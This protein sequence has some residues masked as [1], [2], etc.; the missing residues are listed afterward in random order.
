MSLPLP[1]E[2]L[3][4]SADLKAHV[5]QGGH[6]GAE[7]I[8]YTDEADTFVRK[9]AQ[10]STGSARLLKQAVKQRLFAAQG[11]GFPRVRDMGVDTTRRAWF[12]MDYV[13][14]RTLGDLVRTQAP[15]D[16]QRIIAAIA[17]LLTLFRATESGTLSADLFRAKIADIARVAEDNAAAKHLAVLRRVAAALDGADWSGIPVSISHGDLTFENILIAPDG[18]VSFIDCDE[19]FASSW[20]LDVGKLF[21]DVAGAWC[22]HTLAA[23]SVGATERLVRFDGEL[24]K[25]AAELAPALPSRLLQFAAL[26]LLRTVPYSKSET[27]VVFAIRRAARLLEIGS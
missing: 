16:G 13:P 2:V 15:F 17:N 23:P 20:W 10:R 25:L 18:V 7:V 21:Q 27:A 4:P 3:R 11:L 8:L 14:A 5:L 9:R 26:H 19:P 24:R 1:R 6:S 22:L 12:E